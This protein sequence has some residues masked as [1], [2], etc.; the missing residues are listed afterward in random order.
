[1]LV[2]RSF[3]TDI[4]PW[5]DLED[6]S[7]RFARL[8]G[9]PMFSA[10]ESGVFSPAVQIVEN[11]KELVVTAELPG[12]KKEDVDIQVE[13]GVLTITG[14]KKR[15]VEET[16]PTMHVWE[17]SYGAFERAFTLPHHLDLDK[18]TADFKKGVLVIRIPKA[19]RTNGKKVTIE[20]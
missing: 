12:M 3:P 13:D 8:M 9:A 16:K 1:M 6:L 19:A 18:V 14:E 17:R 5:R 20:G 15:E 10:K 4:S 11:E 7:A 2:K